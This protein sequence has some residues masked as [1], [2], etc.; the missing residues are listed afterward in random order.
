VDDREVHACALA[1]RS[2]RQTGRH[3]VCDG[4]D[5]FAPGA[6]SIPVTTMLPSGR[7]QTQPIWVTGDGEHLYLNTEVH[8]VK[9]KNIQRDPRVT[10]MIWDRDDLTPENW[11]T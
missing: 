11:S 10:V 2:T 6:T 1:L 7:F 4:S 3:W 5:H 9:F 8:R